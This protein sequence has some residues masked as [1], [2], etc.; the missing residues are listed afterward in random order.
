M[1]R[2]PKSTI[3][4]IVISATL[5]FLLIG[6]MGCSTPE[7]KA[8]KYFQKGSVL[9]EKG[10][11]A[12]ASIEY[13]N[14]LQIKKTMA[15]AIYGLALIAE[16]KGEWQEMFGLL[17]KVV[18][19]D[20]KHVEAQIKLGSILLAAEKLDK[21]LEVSNKLLALDKDN[22]AILA[23]R[24]AVLLK[25]GDPKGALEQANLALTKKQDNVEALVVLASERIAAG[26]LVKAISYLDT[27]LK[28]NP[29]SI[30]L[31][32]LK[33]SALENMPDLP[34]AEEVHRKLIEYNPDVGAFRV[35][36]TQFYTK[37]KMLDKAELEL[38]A[39]SAKS[40][41]DF[42][43]KLDIV[44]FVNST[45]GPQAARQ[46][47][48]N[49]AKNEPAN[50]EFK[51]ALVGFYQSQKDPV[52]AEK[53]L[54]EVIA[55]SK[56]PADTA[57][58]KVML[59]GK[60]LSEGKKEAAVKLVDEVLV[61]DARNEQALLMKAGLDIDDRKFDQAVERLR[62]ILRDAPNS[63]R[64]LLLLATAHNLSGA[65]ELADE[66][67]LRAFQAG[68]MAP[69]FGM[70]YAEFLLKR[71][72]P[73]RA[74]KILQDMLAVNQKYVPGLKMLAQAKISRSDWVGAQRVADEIKSIGNAGPVADQIMGVI[75][76]GQKNYGES[77]AAFQR[78]HD[79]APA[80]AQPVA[81]L[82]RTYMLAGKQKEALSF[83]S[84]VLASNP[85]NI[86]ARVMQ[87]QIYAASGEK[88]KAI[89]SFKS[90]I[91]QAPKATVGYQQ[92]A[93]FYM[94][95]KQPEEAQQTIA[96]GL[97]A[98]PNDFGLRLTQA[99][100][101]EL[102]NKFDDAIKSYESLIKERP[103]AEVIVNNLVSL[104]TDHRT[105]KASFE[106]A[107]TLGQSLSR[108][109]VPYFKDTYGW[110]SYKAGKFSEAVTSLESATKA[111][112]D[113][114]IFQYHLGM[115]YAA[116]ADKPKARKALEKALKLA[117]AKQPV[118][119]DEIINTL[120]GL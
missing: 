113:V 83:L 66:H 37:H 55:S 98:V 46:E 27:G 69:Q 108:S 85:S 53:I 49:Y 65:A 73:Q 32:I 95:E 114:A 17:S 96:Q 77:I 13:H 81:A 24:A 54:N 16:K 67:Y 60:H 7:E 105:D 76:A 88:Q 106:R 12:K 87:G 82:V 92:L 5:S 78:A 2:P 41:T 45:K 80:D 6:M 84:S 1:N 28:S 90:V 56:T 59:A 89:E 103:G 72:Q 64:A 40:P 93:S 11:Y 112:P 38:R 118:P 101:F 116:S 23:F 71:N 48:E 68:K 30:A 111:L 63:T 33:V 50:N 119:Q 97:I 91:S 58:A 75:Q 39:I 29:K 8:N 35:A 109:D 26:D 43:A 86:D 9:L 3:K 74:E 15:P 44:R 42:Q 31:N 94:R 21:A 99:G 20:P 10:D 51:F 57:K 115:A 70:P 14:A 102:A 18:E 62:T 4:K 104:I 34:K 22:S 117:D 120:K 79:S 61:A 25:T 36:L 47:L 110:A 100:V 52:T 19:Q 107:Y